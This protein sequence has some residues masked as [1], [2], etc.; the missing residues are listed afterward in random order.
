M[1]SLANDIV[2]VVPEGKEEK[3]RRILKQIEEE[4]SE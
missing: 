1:S 4:E 2:M 3:A